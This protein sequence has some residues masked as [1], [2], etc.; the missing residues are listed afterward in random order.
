M[1]NLK[2]TQI[3][4]LLNGNRLTDFEKLTYQRRQ[5]GKGS[6]GLGSW[7]G[8]VLKLGCDDG[9]TTTNIIK[10]TELKNELEFPLWCNGIRGIPA[11]PRG[12]FNPKPITV[13]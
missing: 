11:V 10:F 5:F 8:N 13:G 2:N 12:R 7:D 4:Y 6:D 9:C 1:W 3:L